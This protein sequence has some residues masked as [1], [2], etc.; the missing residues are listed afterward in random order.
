MGGRSQ[1]LNQAVV[2]ALPTYTYK[3]VGAPIPM[4]PRTCSVTDTSAVTYVYASSANVAPADSYDYTSADPMDPMVGYAYD[5]G[6]CVD[7][8]QYYYGS[9][10]Y[11]PM[12]GD[13]HPQ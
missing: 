3:T 10:L 13:R 1:N 4:H 9:R 11:E 5:S 12:L 6:Q 2:S 8:G 7:A